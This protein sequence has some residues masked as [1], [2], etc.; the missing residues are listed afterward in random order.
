MNQ[1]LVS[2]TTSNERW[3]QLCGC[4]QQTVLCR[5]GT[6]TTS[7]SRLINV[8]QLKYSEQIYQILKKGK[9]ISRELKK[10]QVAV[11]KTTR[12]TTL[13]TRTWK[14]G[15][16]MWEKKATSWK[17]LKQKTLK[18]SSSGL[19]NE[20]KTNDISYLITKIRFN[21]LIFQRIRN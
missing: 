3:H 15:K 5:T 21:A 19:K 18:R 12:K 1:S 8:L 13:S 9:F 11:S 14:R 16:S 10:Y 2:N 4:M 17:K 7:T 20:I 6:H